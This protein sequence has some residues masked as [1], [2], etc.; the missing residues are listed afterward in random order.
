MLEDLNSSSINKVECSDD[1][2]DQWGQVIQNS[3]AIACME[4]IV[5]AHKL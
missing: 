3:F 1:M 4:H 2:E 5:M